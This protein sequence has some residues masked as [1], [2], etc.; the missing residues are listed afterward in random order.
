MVLLMS[1]ALNLDIVM[2]SASPMVST[3]FERRRFAWRYF[4]QRCVT[5][6]HTYDLARRIVESHN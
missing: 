5:V 6:I 4:I 3:S 1:P 2:I